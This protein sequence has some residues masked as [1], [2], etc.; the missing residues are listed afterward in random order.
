MAALVLN[1]LLM[2]MSNG[3]G[4]ASER[5]GSSTSKVSSAFRAFSIASLQISSNRH[6]ALQRSDA[7]RQKGTGASRLRSL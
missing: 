5:G 4:H 6:G 3:N 7:V 2:N 1:P